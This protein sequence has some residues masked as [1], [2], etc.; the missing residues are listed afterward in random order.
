MMNLAVPHQGQETT[1]PASTGAAFVDLDNTLIH[2]SALYQIARGMVAHG[3]VSRRQI[4]SFARRQAAFRLRGEH[5]SHMAFVRDATL[6]L[7]DGRDA[8][9]VERVGEQIYDQRVAGRLIPEMLDVVQSHLDARRQV[10][11]VTAAP[12]ELASIIARRLGCTGTLGTIC[13]RDGGKYTGRIIGPVLHGSAKADAVS[14]LMKRENLAFAGCFAYSDSINDLPMLSLVGYP[15]AVNP[16]RQLR[17]VARERYWPVL[18]FR[19]LRA[20]RREHPA[21]QRTLAPS[22]RD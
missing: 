3:V 7:A 13:E 17:A 20:G 4:V 6:A 19:R 14:A 21:P 16:D 8:A 1:R 5:V 10:W 15:Q 2:G 18:D 11:I 22:T 12:I 9:E